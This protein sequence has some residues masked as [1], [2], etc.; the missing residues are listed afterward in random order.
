MS[1]ATCMS[2]LG[3]CSFKSFAHIYELLLSCMSCLYIWNINFLS[4]ASLANIFSHVEKAGCFFHYVHDFLCYPKAFKINQ[5]PFLKI[6]LLL[7]Q[8]IEWKCVPCYLI[9]RI[10]II[11]IT[12]F[13][14]SIFIFNEI[15]SKIPRTFSTELKLIILNFNETTKDPEFQG[16]SE[17]K[18]TKLEV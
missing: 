5:V 3:K 12:V 4:M 14:K 11:K 6:L 2:S 13:P 17:K 18:V 15:H 1:L 9:G 7:H 8:K 16:N 10:N